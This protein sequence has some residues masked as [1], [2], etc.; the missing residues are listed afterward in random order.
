MARPTVMTPEV[1][2]THNDLYIWLYKQFGDSPTF[3][4]VSRYFPGGSK[5]SFKGVFLP[6]FNRIVSRYEKTRLTRRL[7]SAKQRVKWHFAKT[8]TDDGSITNA[9]VIELLK[10]QG[11]CCAI[12]TTYLTKEKHKQLDHI[13]PLSKGGQHVLGNVQWLCRT[14]NIRKKDTYEPTQ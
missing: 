3:P 6:R 10:S 4:D 11:F 14:C 5:D 7:I 13:R 9:T 2:A 8:S 12:C 1:I